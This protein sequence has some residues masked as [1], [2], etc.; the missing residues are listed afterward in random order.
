MCRFPPWGKFN[1]A[2]GFS[3]LSRTRDW[4]RG[5]KSYLSLL[6]K[7]RSHDDDDGNPELS[8]FMQTYRNLNSRPHPEIMQIVKTLRVWYVVE[9]KHTPNL[10]SNFSCLSV[11]EVDHLYFRQ[12]KWKW[13]KFGWSWTCLMLLNYTL[14]EVGWLGRD[15]GLH[16]VVNCIKIC[17]TA[18]ENEVFMSSCQQN[19]KFACP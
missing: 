17:G 12:K 14:A 9:H 11:S 7:I 4:F 19:W 3:P 13:H 1:L 6:A 10:V 2:N 8:N 5:Q 18:V 15:R 16:H